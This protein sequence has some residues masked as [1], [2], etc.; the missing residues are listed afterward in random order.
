L[1]LFLLN[2]R[3]AEDPLAERGIEG[4]LQTVSEWATK[5]SQEYARCVRRRSRGRLADFAKDGGKR[6]LRLESRGVFFGAAVSSWS[7]LFPAPKPNS[8]GSY[9]CCAGCC[10]VNL[11]AIAYVSGWA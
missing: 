7:L 8:G 10:H 9:P 5:F 1:A 4:S 11:H 3:H 6:Y 2:L